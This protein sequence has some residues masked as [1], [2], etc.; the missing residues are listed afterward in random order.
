MFVSKSECDTNSNEEQSKEQ[1]NNTCF[2]RQHHIVLLNERLH[3]LQ[4]VSST[5]KEVKNL[6]N[7]QMAIRTPDRV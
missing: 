6:G 4:N 2:K 1:F 7:K 5:V 3:N